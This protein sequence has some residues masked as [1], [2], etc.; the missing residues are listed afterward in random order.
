MLAAKQVAYLMQNFCATVKDLSYCFESLLHNIF[1]FSL[2]K[3]LY[4]S[5]GKGRGGAL[6]Q[7]MECPS[8][9]HLPPPVISV[10][11]STKLPK[12]SLFPHCQPNWTGNALLQLFIVITSLVSGAPLSLETE[13]I[14]NS[15]SPLTAFVAY[16]LVQVKFS[17]ITVPIKNVLAHKMF[18][19]YQGAVLITLW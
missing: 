5:I 7:G 13:D 18:C 6:L 10:Q 2:W 17:L 14:D 16:L 15:C 12:S 4:Q 1:F 19:S 3:I 8:Q 9:H 11:V